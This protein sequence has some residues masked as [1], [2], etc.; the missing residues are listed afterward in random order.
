M[1]LKEWREKSA[2]L[3]LGSSHTVIYNKALRLI[4]KYGEGK[5]FLDFG[6]GQGQFVSRVL[7]KNIFTQVMAI[8]LMKKP[9]GISSTVEWFS[10]DLNEKVDVPDSSVDFISCLEVIEHLENPRHTMRELYRLLAP[11]GCLLLSTPNNESWRSIVS[12]CARGHFVDFTDSS[13]PAHITALNRKDLTRIST[14]CGFKII[15]WEFTDQGSLPGFTRWTWQNLS[16]SLLKGLR[17]SDN[18]FIVL[19]KTI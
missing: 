5:T 16:L 11:D 14:E 15:V 6:A 17:Y 3:S 7:N 2:D 18:I 1:E 10:A 8:D 12:Y 19:K 13:Y 4:E 9:N